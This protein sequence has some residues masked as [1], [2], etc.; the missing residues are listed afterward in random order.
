[1]VSYII[2]F[3]IL[4]LIAYLYLKIADHFNIIDNPNHRSSHTEP[5]IRG[6][7]IIFYLAVLIF[8]ILA[9]FHY[10][11]F[12]IA[13]TL[14]AI[15]SFLDDILSLGKRL[16]L[17]VHFASAI[18]LMWQ[19]QLL[20]AH[21]PV[22]VF[23]PIMIVGFY[24]L[25]NFMDGIN[26]L[27]AV[28]SMVVISGFLSI[29]T[30]ENLIDDRLLV[31]LLLSLAIFSFYNLRKKARWFA[32]DIGSITMAAC[33]FFLGALFVKELN[34]PVLILFIVVYAVDAMLTI[35]LRALRKEKITEAHRHHLYQKFV[36]VGHY[37][38]SQVAL[39]YG[40]VQI[41]INVLVI[42]CY[43]CSL[44]AQYSVVIAM[45]LLMGGLYLFLIR[46]FDKKQLRSAKNA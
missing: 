40:A 4:F 18:L 19:L 9:G 25:Y 22:L 7:G 6:G 31:Y 28:Y 38:H 3:V 44:F 30:I 12:F 16:R 42:Y 21:W 8:F 14:L 5:T 10:M 39:L 15:I 26:G 33:I 46:Y 11:P 20:D 32:G 35:A 1:M 23:L 27:T 37:S 41:I 45:C 24:N 2:V 36:D 13:I 29:N 43:T 34:A 17:L